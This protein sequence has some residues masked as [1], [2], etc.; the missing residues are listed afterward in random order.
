MHQG[1]QPAQML[2]Q[3]ARS[4][5]VESG[6][7]G[8]NLPANDGVGVEPPSRALGASDTPG[9]AGQP[10]QPGATGVEEEIHRQVEGLPA[11]PVQQTQGS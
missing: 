9:N 2:S 6:V 10:E 11:Q 8:G 5:G 4:H 7:A 3:P 1:R